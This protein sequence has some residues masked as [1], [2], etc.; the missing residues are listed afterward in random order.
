MTLN[1]LVKADLEGIV[2]DN[3]T[4]LATDVLY[5]GVSVTG[6]WIVKDNVVEDN[7]EGKRERVRRATLVCS[8]TDVPVVTPQ[9]DT[10]KEGGNTY[11]VTGSFNEAGGLRTVMCEHWS[12]LG[13]NVLTKETIR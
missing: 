6:L 12:V 3:T 9:V 7:E 8:I 11:L 2:N 13:R 1:D 5:N 10:I 4:G